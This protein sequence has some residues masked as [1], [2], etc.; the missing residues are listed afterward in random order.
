[1][2]VLLD[3]LPA[4]GFLMLNVFIPGPN[5]MNTIA[6]AMGS[7]R[8][9]GLS[10]AIACGC[11]LCVWAV[12]A[13]LGAAAVFATLPVAQIVMTTIGGLLLLYFALR[14]I[15][16]SMQPVANFA[17]IS[18]VSFR[19]AFI[20]AFLVMLSNPKVLT[21]WLAV[22]S[23]FPIVVSDGLHIFG[24]VIL[25]S[26]GSFCGHALVATLFSTGPASRLYMRLYRPINAAVGI[27]F[28]L[29]GL[30]LLSNLVG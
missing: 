17:A 12:V 29:Y 18:N 11:G 27:G 19:H 9:T 15:K 7:G 24:F 28:C 5:V 23:L 1:M 8:R 22:I 3:L 14:Y 10:C 2:T 30:K 26:L 16:K 25:A 20:Q 21:T 13:L 6:T 4:L